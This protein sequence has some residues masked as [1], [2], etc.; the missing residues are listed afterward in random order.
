MEM[1]KF[2]TAALMAAVAI[3][4]IA[5]P[6]AASAQSNREVRRDREQLREERGELRDAQRRGDRRDVREERRDVR[7][8]RQELREDV[9]DRNRNWRQNDWQDYRGRNRGVFARGNWRAPFRYQNFRPGLRIGVNFYSPRYRI[10]DP[11]RY[12]LPRPGYNQAWVR[13]YNDILLVDIR[14]GSVIRVLRNFY[15]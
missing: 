4:T 14:R 7:E 13:H 11:W 9:R 12:R 10:S 1:K 8:A 2:I 15:W 5:M 3:P 6:T